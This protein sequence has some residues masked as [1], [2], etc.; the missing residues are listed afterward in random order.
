M[1]VTDNVQCFGETTEATDTKRYGDRAI[2]RQSSYEIELFV[3]RWSDGRERERL[4]SRTLTVTRDNFETEYQEVW[5]QRR[6]EAGSRGA[7]L[8]SVYLGYAVDG[9]VIHSAKVVPCWACDG[10]VLIEDG[11]HRRNQYCSDQC[12]D[13]L[14]RR[15]QAERKRDQRSEQRT[16]RPCDQCGESFTPKR[17]DAKFCSARCRVAAHRK[18]GG[19]R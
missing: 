12:R 2:K 5:D 18:A 10:L 11:D 16:P 1:S 9:E 19:K 4:W 7:P 17:S 3:F 6:S 14:N 15:W 13:D 8:A